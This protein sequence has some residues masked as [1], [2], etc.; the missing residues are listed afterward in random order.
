MVLHL[1][2]V[3]SVF[4]WHEFLRSYTKFLGEEPMLWLMVHFKVI[5]GDDGNVL[6]EKQGYGADKWERQFKSKYIGNKDS[7]RILIPYRTVQ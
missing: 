1:L 3:T 4:T 7:S 2:C 6:E 5:Q